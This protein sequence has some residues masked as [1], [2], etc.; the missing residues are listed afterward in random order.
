M[1]DWYLTELSGNGLRW[2]YLK[3][4]QLR[5]THEALQSNDALA[6]RAF[7]DAL[8]K[9]I[10]NILCHCLMSDMT[11]SSKLVFRRVL[12]PSKPEKKSQ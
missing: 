8:G 11:I 12:T 7:E 5:T 1:F 9:S 10:S 3:P 4:G 6:G 2:R